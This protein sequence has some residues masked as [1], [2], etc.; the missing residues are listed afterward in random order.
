MADDGD[1]IA[2]DVGLYRREGDLVF[3]S[4]GDGSVPAA[5]RLARVT[6]VER[7]AMCIRYV[8][9]YERAWLWLRGRW[10]RAQERWKTA[11]RRTFG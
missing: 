9:W 11:V 2:P 6:R 8:R 1:I 10:W 4:S 3:T 5:P 7:D